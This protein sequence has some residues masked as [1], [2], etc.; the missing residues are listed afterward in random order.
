MGRI[1]DDA[2]LNQYRTQ[3]YYHPLDVLTAEEAAV[4]E[5]CPAASVSR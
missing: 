5:F 3:G 4:C 2:A 1:L